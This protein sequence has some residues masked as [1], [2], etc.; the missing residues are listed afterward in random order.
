MDNVKAITKWTDGAG[1]IYDDEAAAIQ[2]ECRRIVRLIVSE[3]YDASRRN[4]DIDALVMRRTA[5][6]DALKKIERQP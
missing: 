5:L 3:A 4:L 6:I 1:V 2:G